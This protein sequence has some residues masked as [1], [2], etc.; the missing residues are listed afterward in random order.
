VAH[1]T[2]FE[3]VTSAFG[4]QV[5]GVPRRSFEALVNHYGYEKYI[6]NEKSL[7]SRVRKIIDIPLVVIAI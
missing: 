5:P 6:E 3:P 7:H 4:V 2:G 1:P